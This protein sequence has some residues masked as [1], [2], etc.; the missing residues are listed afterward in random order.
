MKKGE[1][2]ENRQNHR[3]GRMI[4]MVD[5]R[6]KGTPMEGDRKRLELGRQNA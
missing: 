3:D 5:G 4:K 1:R 6:L 2:E